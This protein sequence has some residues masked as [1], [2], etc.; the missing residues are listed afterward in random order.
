MQE[1]R[2]GMELAQVDQ[3]VEITFVVRDEVPQFVM[4]QEDQAL[5]RAWNAGSDYGDGSRA[6][7]GTGITSLELVMEAARYFHNHVAGERE[8]YRYTCEGW[9]YWSWPA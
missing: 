8:E 3:E 1:Q 4:T 5:V 7:R 6:W 2:K 9:Q